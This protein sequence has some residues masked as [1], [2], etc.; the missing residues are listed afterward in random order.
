MVEREDIRGVLDPR[1]SVGL[2][3]RSPGKRA[4]IT[5]FDLNLAR[6]SDGRWWQPL[7]GAML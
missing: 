6:A 1:R 5:W 2:P 3:V 4:A 7:G